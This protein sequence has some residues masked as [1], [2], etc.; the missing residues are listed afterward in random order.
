M[1]GDR[2]KATYSLDAET[3]KFIDRLARRWKM[4]KSEVVRRVVRGAVTDHRPI[5]DDPEAW[6]ERFRELQ[7]LFELSESRFDEWQREN[8]A[9]RRASSRHRG[10]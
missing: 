10:V 9:M 6:I 2:I 7:R 1:T 3:I 4:S 8:R 5:A